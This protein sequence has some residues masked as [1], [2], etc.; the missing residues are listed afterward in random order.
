MRILGN[1]LLTE[2]QVMALQ[3]EEFVKESNENENGETTLVD[4]SESSACCCA[5]CLE[6][7]QDKER[8]RVLPCKH[9]FHGDC[10]IPWLTERH[11]TCPLCKFDVL[12]H[13][14]T[15]ENEE[16]EGDE[17]KTTTD[18][19]AASAADTTGTNTTTPTLRTRASWWTNLLRGYTHVQRTGSSD[20][21]SAESQEEGS[22][23]TG[24]PVV[25]STGSNDAEAEEASNAD[26]SPPEAPA[27]METP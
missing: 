15:G 4:E 10:V 19:A 2:A 17:N 5:I 9:K 8:V 12:E 23:T 16:E 25:V 22:T 11:C 6:E 3:E 7:F 20:S 18:A 26:A 14:L 1:G 27:P 21:E 13:I 24:S